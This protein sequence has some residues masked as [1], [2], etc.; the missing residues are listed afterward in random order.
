MQACLDSLLEQTHKDF[1]II[2]VDNGSKDG[3][4]EILKKNYS[5]IKIIE[6]EKMRDSAKGNNQGIKIAMGQYI[7]TLNNDTVTDRDWLK[8]LV[9]TIESGPNVGMC[10]SKILSSSDHSIIDSVGIKVCLDGMSRGVG[11]MEKDTGQYSAIQEIL[12][13]SACAALYRKK[14][15]DEIGLF[16]EDFFAYCEDTD[17]GLRAV[18]MGWKALLNPGR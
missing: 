6:N 16:D 10:G 12:L 5:E 14:M 18:L 11:R 4:L 9:F 3:S 7:A 1:E 13:P 8:N 2:L 15:L 17:L